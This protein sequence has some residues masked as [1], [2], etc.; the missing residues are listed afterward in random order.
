MIRIPLRESRVYLPLLYTLPKGRFSIVFRLQ[1]KNALS[2]AEYSLRLTDTEQLTSVVSS[3]SILCFAPEKVR[4]RALKLNLDNQFTH[5]FAQSVPYVN[6]VGSA[7]LTLSYGMRITAWNIAHAYSYGLTSVGRVLLTQSNLE[8]LQSYYHVSWRIPND[9]TY[10]FRRA[11]P[12]FS[13]WN[14]K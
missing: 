11:V 8:E 3:T 1:N 9:V 12:R 4:L 14:V 13:T 10:S 2:L 5:I 6:S 7:M